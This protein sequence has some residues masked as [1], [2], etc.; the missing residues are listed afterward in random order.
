MNIL[1]SV[2]SKKRKKSEVAD[3]GSSD[4]YSFNKTAKKLV[5]SMEKSQEQTSQLV[6][7]MLKFLATKATELQVN[8]PR[9][10]LDDRDG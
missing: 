9:G 8:L 1:C 6:A 10:I 3:S 7:A 4:E 2:D 5:A